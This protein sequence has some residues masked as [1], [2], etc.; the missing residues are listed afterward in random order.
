[1]QLSAYTK[2]IQI[3]DIHISEPKH[4]PNG[5]DVRQNFERV[6]KEIALLEFDVL[7]LTGDLCWDVGNEDIYHWIKDLLEQYLQQSYHVIAGNHD[8]TVIMAD[9]F[10]KTDLLKGEELYFEIDI[11]HY[12]VLSLDTAVGRLSMEQ[13]NW[14]IDHVQKAKEDI[15]IFM[16]HPPIL[17]LVYYMDTNHALHEHYEILK[18]LQATS[19]NVNVFCG[20]FHTDKTIHSKNVT[21]HLTPSLYAQINSHTFKFQIDHTEVGYRLITAGKDYLNT[22]VRYLR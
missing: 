4:H 12:K 2:I 21:V 13:K 9:A 6:L 14:L 11:P 17:G 15:I 5:V 16:H 18:I 20:H 19:Q 3:T 1:M 7:W 22:E 8:N 10:G